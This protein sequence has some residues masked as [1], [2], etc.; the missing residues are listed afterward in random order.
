MSHRHRHVV[1]GAAR[2][3]C[4]RSRFLALGPRRGAS[5]GSRLP[6]AGAVCGVRVVRRSGRSR[7][8]PFRHRLH[9]NRR[10]VLAARHQAL[11]LGR[12]VT[13]AS[14]RAVVH[15]R[16]PPDAVGTRRRPSGWRRGSGIPLLRGTGYHIRRRAHVRGSRRG[17]CRTGERR[18]QPRHRRDPPALLRAGMS[19]TAFEEHETVPWQALAD[20]Q[21]ERLDS[22][23]WRLVDRPERLAATYTLQ[24]VKH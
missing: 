1:V 13:A 7:R 16:R 18:V 21:M 14:R 12:C 19:I 6:A 11:G 17:P 2:G 8:Q 24:A 5:T 22:G 3:T 10:A 23:E 4:D 9:R 15:A 20:G